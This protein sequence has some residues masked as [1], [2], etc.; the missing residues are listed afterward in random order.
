MLPFATTRSSQ[1][2]LF[3]ST[4]VEGK[5]FEDVSVESRVTMARWAWGNKFVDFN[6]D[7][8]EDLVVANGF[9]TTSD[10]SDL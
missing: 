7:G 3:R 9:I 5:R 10:K 6:N 1:P 4:N 8:W 2:S